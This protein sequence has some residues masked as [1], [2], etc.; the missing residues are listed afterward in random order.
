MVWSRRT[1]TAI[2]EVMLASV[3][4][5]PPS[6]MAQS[7]STTP[8]D[9]PL[10]SAPS[11]DNARE[12]SKATHEAPDLFDMA[13]EHG[14]YATVFLN[15]E[16]AGNPSGGIRQGVA[17]SQYVI[18]GPEF[19]FQRLVGW[20]GASLHA[21]VIAENS[22]G[23]SQKYIGGG[24]DVQENFAPFNFCR[25]FDLTLAQSIAL[26]DEASL[27]LMAG[28]TAAVPAFGESQYAGLFMNHAF[29]GP[30]YG[31][32]QS[33]GTAVA[34]LASWGGAAKLNL[35]PKVYLKFGGYAV[36]AET[37]QAGTQIF[38]FDTSGVTGVNY[39]WEAGYETTFA[40]DPA[41]RY[42]R[43][44]FSFV[45]A[46][47]NDVLLNTDGLPLFA[48]GG[49]PLIH[50][51]ETAIYAT[52]GQVVWRPDHESQRNVAVFGSVYYNLVESESIQYAIKAGVV[53]TG[54]FATR[55]NDTLS[56]GMA[57]VSLT[58]KEVD[59]LSGMRSNGGGSG[60]VPGEE[61]IVELNYGFQLLPGM[62][63]R[64]NLQYIVNPN[65]GYTP[66]FPHNIPNVFVV[67]LQA[68]VSLD[69]LFAMPHLPIEPADNSQ[70][71]GQNVC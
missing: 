25:F 35:T 12:G 71:K 52:G 31:F 27:E 32:T 23:L 44:G 6:A 64:P 66:T 26:W 50:H 22:T 49:T 54:P 24:V 33:S 19:D 14:V 30:L 42:Y 45:D 28:R 18:F 59:F 21:L 63:V 58:S 3:F 48:Y 38:D 41:P 53:Q 51:G 10:P 4:L 68:T 2:A 9:P 55:P 36:D 11:E 57:V 67:G 15:E 29:S 16:L 43:I 37:L 70:T 40:N 69:T 17:A 60:R 34:P 39:L 61:W 65:P 56:L 20:N 62:V 1:A 47:R 5:S 46:P 13:A 8:S 7:L